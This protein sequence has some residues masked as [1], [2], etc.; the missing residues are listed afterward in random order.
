MSDEASINE[1]GVDIFEKEV[2][3]DTANLLNEA[4]STDDNLSDLSDDPELVYADFRNRLNKNLKGSK[5]ASKS[6]EDLHEINLM[7]SYL[8]VDK[9]K[10]RN[11]VQ[12]SDDSLD[13]IKNEKEEGDEIEK[14]K[15]K[16]N[17]DLDGTE[18][19]ETDC[20]GELKTPEKPVKVK[21]HLKT[22]IKNVVAANLLTRKQKCFYLF[23]EGIVDVCKLSHSDYHSVEG[24]K[25][26]YLKW[27]R[28]NVILDNFEIKGSK[29]RV[30]EL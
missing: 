12:C 27:E 26:K 18:T 29:V 1:V 13:D 20:L 7:N 28:H 21:K 5:C 10:T 11:I 30:F 25:H 3:I 17:S 8:D 22:Q 4:S 15:Y 9:Y 19:K 6:Y 23:E 14:A 24:L 16:E 2:N